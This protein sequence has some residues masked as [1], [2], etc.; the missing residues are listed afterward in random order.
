[1]T[2]SKILPG[3]ATNPDDHAMPL[4]D[5]LEELRSVLIFSLV[6]LL[7]GAISAYNFHQELIALLI[8]PLTELE[9]KP[10][11]V[12]A[13]EGFFAALKVSAFAGLVI[14]SPAIL[15][16]IWSFIVPALYS[17]ERRYVYI[18]FPFSVLLFLSGV[19]FSYMTVYPLGVKFLITFGDF[20][21]MISISE[22]LG[23]ALTFILPFGIIFQLPV[24]LIFL[25]RMGLITHQLLAKYRQYALLAMFVI[26]AV[27]TPTPDI[28]TQ[29]LMALPM[30]LLY[31]ISIWMIR[32]I[33]PKKK[34]LPEDR[35]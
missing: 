14:A 30:Y 34:T 2:N 15:W 18:F 1:M 27:I 9:I 23:F 12:R 22:F 11:I 6:A 3:T 13:T 5:H 31:E 32:L 16:K 29:T 25:A 20:T 35:A 33:R 8:R 19:A 7:L 21:P 28:V 4:M 10:V 24:I 17:H 26:A